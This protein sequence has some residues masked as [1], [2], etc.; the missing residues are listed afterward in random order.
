MIEKALWLTPPTCYANANINE[1]NSKNCRDSR[2]GHIEN[3][4]MKMRQKSNRNAANYYFFSSFAFV[5]Y[6]LFIFF[7]SLSK[8]KEKK[9]ILQCISAWL[10]IVTFTHTSCAAIHFLTINENFITIFYSRN[11]IFLTGNTVLYVQIPFFPCIKSYRNEHIKQ[12]TVFRFSKVHNIFL[13]SNS[14]PLVLIVL[15]NIYYTIVFFYLLLLNVF[16]II[17][18]IL[19]VSV[20]WWLS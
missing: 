2:K 6:C 14:V 15:Y 5:S 17:V 10:K 1:Q 18:I 20:M 13:V 12:Y 8:R 7:L 11:V 9:I 16:I 3:S 4:L 19:A